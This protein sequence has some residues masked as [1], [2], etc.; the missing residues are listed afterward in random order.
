MCAVAWE[1]SGLRI[2]VGIGGHIYFAN[3]RHD[4]K[5]KSQADSFLVESD[6][7]YHYWLLFCS[8]G[9]FQ[10]LLCTPTGGV[11]LGRT[12]VC[13]GTLS[14]TTRTVRLVTSCYT[15]PLVL[16][17]GSWQPKMTIV[18]H[19]GKY[20]RLVLAGLATCT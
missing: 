16:T 14:T 8:G 5:V 17:M 7:L 1:G 3:I 6:E 18:N 4:Y 13:S 12:V 20:V 10:T 11:G 9:T 2:A 19:R 15:S